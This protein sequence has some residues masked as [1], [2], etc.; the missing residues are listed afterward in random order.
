MARPHVPI[1]QMNGRWAAL[2]KLALLTYPILLTAGLTWATWVT[3]SVLELNTF[4]RGGPRWTEKDAE[5][6]TG[7]IRE[8]VEKRLTES[9]PPK[10]VLRRLDGLERM[11]ATANEHVQHNSVML[12]TTASQL[13]SLVRGMTQA[14]EER[15][16]T[17][18]KKD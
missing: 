14:S 6:Q 7:V 4:M 5:L 10:D 12:A 16:R 9:V 3:A 1:G 8:W 17:K 11:M 2:L 13:D 15:A 18:L